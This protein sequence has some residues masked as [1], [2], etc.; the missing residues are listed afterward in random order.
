MKKVLRKNISIFFI[1]LSLLSASWGILSAP[2]PAE[3]QWAVEDILKLPTDILEQNIFPTITDIVKGFTISFAYQDLLKWISGEG[4]G[5]PAFITNFDQWLYDKA[6]IAASQFL[7]QTLG[8][9]Y[10]VLCT[11]INVNLALYWKPQFEETKFDVPK[12]TLSEIQQRFENPGTQWVDFQATLTGTNSDAGYLFATLDLANQKQAEETFKN[13]TE[14]IAGQGYVSEDEDG[15]IKT[16]G[17]SIA[18]LVNAGTQSLYDVGTNSTGW[19]N[20]VGPLIEA[21]IQGALKKGFNQFN[22][23]NL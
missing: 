4:G 20:F 7:D 14:A 18:D 22:Q 12:C 11:G 8:D 5:K 19:F 2:Q 1:V 23:L 21:A 13:F 16:P 9:A 3:A 6:D 17:S 15:N 10:N